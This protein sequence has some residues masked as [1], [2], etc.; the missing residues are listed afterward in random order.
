MDSNHQLQSSISSGIC[1]ALYDWINCITELLNCIANKKKM[2]VEGKLEHCNVHVVYVIIHGTASFY[3]V[4]TEAL[5]PPTL[6][7]CEISK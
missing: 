4:S 6:T 7:D 5:F 2:S 1:L 3:I